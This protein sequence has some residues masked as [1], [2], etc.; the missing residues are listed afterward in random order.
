MRS[1]T[2]LV[3]RKGMGTSARARAAGMRAR[4]LDYENQTR[5]GVSTN[6]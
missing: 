4:M 3:V 5:C 6:T 2:R 1:L